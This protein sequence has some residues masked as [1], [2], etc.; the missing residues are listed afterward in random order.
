MNLSY[1]TFSSLFEIFVTYC[2]QFVCVFSFCWD[3][4]SF[5]FPGLLQVLLLPQLPDLSGTTGVHHLAC[6]QFLKTHIASHSSG[7]S[8]ANGKESV[9]YSCYD[10]KKIYPFHRSVYHA[11]FK[12]PLTPLLISFL[13]PHE[14]RY[15]C[16]SHF[17]A[18]KVRCREVAACLGSLN[19][20]LQV[21]LLCFSPSCSCL[22]NSL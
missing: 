5:C 17:T 13:Q 18:V 1:S 20:C 15:Y 21:R 16:S 3:G 11:L 10:V 12:V 8:W 2:F 9:L 7:W 6:L 22:G 14:V 19:W 4:F